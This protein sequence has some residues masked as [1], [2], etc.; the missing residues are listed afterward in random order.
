MPPLAQ[1]LK[2]PS[3]IGDMVPQTPSMIPPAPPVT[4]VD[5]SALAIGATGPAPAIMTTAYDSY[6]Q[7]VRP[8]VSQTRFP[9]WPV[10]ANPQA[11]T[12]AASGTK[13]IVGSKGFTTLDKVSDGNAR[14]SLHVAHAAPR[15]GN[16]GNRPSVTP[17]G[18][19]A[20]N[21]RGVWLPTTQYFKGDEVVYQVSY[22]MAQKTSLNSTP[23]TGNADWQVIGSYAAF[24]GP[25]SSSTRYV[26]GDEVT[27][28]GN[29][30][31]ATTTNTN[32]APSTSNA[33]W[34]IAGP[35]NLDSVQD[36]TD[37]GRPPVSVYGPNAPIGKLTGF[38]L[39]SN[40]D[41]EIGMNNYVTYDNNG[42]GSVTRSLI[43][44]S[45]AP[46]GIAP[47]GTNQVMKIV[48]ARV[49]VG[50][51]PGLGGFSYG[52]GGA[53]SADT[54]SALAA[55][56]FHIGDTYVIDLLAWIPTGYNLNW[57]S[58]S[59][60]TGG[61]FRWLNSALAN[62]YVSS[63][64]GA[65]AWR[66]YIGVV[67]TGP[68][69]SA[70]AFPY[71]YLT[72]ADG[73]TWYVG[74]L[75]IVDI[76]QSHRHGGRHSVIGSGAHFH[77][78]SAD[79]FGNGY[80][81]HVHFGNHRAFID[82]NP[83]WSMYGTGG[84]DAGFGTFQGG[85][86]NLF[87]VSASGAGPWHL[88]QEDTGVSGKSLTSYMPTAGN[89]RWRERNA[90]TSI[91]HTDM[92]NGLHGYQGS[93]STLVHAFQNSGAFRVEGQASMDFQS[94]DTQ[95]SGRLYSVSSGNSAA[96]IYNIRDITAGV[97]RTQLNN[98]PQWGFYG[99]PS[100]TVEA[101]GGAA[102]RFKISNAAAYFHANDTAVSGVLGI[103]SSG[104]VAAGTVNIQQ[105]V[106]DVAYI[107]NTK[108]WGFYGTPS[109]GVTDVD[110][111]GSTGENAVFRRQVNG[112]GPW[113]MLD[114]NTAT[115]GKTAAK[116]WNNVS[117][118]LEQERTSSTAGA[119]WD[120]GNS[121]FGFNRGPAVDYDLQVS[122]TNGVQVIG[123][124]A[125][126]VRVNDTEASGRN[127]SYNS[128]TAGAGIGGIYDVTGGAARTLLNGTPQWGFYGSPGVDVES[129]GRYIRSTGSAP[130]FDA[131]ST[132][133]GGHDWSYGCAIHIA[134][135][136]A[137]I[138]DN[139]ANAG[140]MNIDSSGDMDFAGGT[141]ATGL[142]AAGVAFADL[143]ANLILKNKND[144]AG[145][146]SSPS[147]NGTGYSVMPEMT[148]TFTTKGN[149]VLLV[150]SAALGLGSSANVA[151][152]GDIAFFRDGVQISPD[153]LIQ[154]S[155]TA[156][157]SVATVGLGGCLSFI[158]APTAASHTYDVRWKV[159]NSSSDAIHSFGT[160]RRF[161]AVELG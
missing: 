115:G 60:G 95:A 112:S 28:L 17:G 45:A 86:R 130:Q 84:G 41:F 55:D 161:Q 38:Y 75:H 114:V 47:N 63:L 122:S 20:Y 67:F 66:H 144:A 102:G 88:I 68:S 37:F 85:T 59:L 129:F 141:P 137:N 146:T 113:S 72:G 140:R 153:Y 36:G 154:S 155:Q 81:T 25:W 56:S 23:A 44:I 147:S 62:T 9:T 110:I 2:K 43:A 151:V 133:T 111:L 13:Q 156:N 3:N 35:N 27:Y 143:S 96:G 34:Q 127:F 148:L 58:N 105:G 50:P 61:Q 24:R 15:G 32:S 152:N 157:G 132:D 74:S 150:F 100:A 78:L 80:L 7:W 22:W 91:Y 89:H 99:S 33:N 90:G 79:D 142:G 104:D 135:S 49:G 4:T 71:F 160:G 48:E 53:L 98:T 76:N 64:P 54:G 77:G 125:I 31:V 119:N 128:G 5:Q 46:S 92:N 82:N 117:T 11:H 8:G 123:S 42:S 1:A 30:W 101:F 131:K 103:F 139:T 136:V 12:T 29:F 109:S 21:F 18:S 39:V 106:A 145:T 16:T 126:N 69:P 94:N 124:G 73:V 6:R 158:D 149:K 83:G 107:P 51:S 108:S 26:A 70:N 14:L 116:F 65:S 52:P 87:K 134:N 10:K 118:T 57:A 97:A 40:P 138:V 121:R 120:Y 93:P 19:V 159:P